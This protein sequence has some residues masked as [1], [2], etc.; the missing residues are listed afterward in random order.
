MKKFATIFVLLFVLSVS[1]FADGQFPIGGKSCPQG[2]VCFTSEGEIPIGGK[3]DNPIIKNV[4]D[5]LKSIF[6]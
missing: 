4:F 3:S 5:F 1:A 6:E 2:Q